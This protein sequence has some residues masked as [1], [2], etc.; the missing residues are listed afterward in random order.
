MAVGSTQKTIAHNIKSGLNTPVRSV[1]IIIEQSPIRIGRIGPVGIEF[2]LIVSNQT[3]ILKLL[4]A[5]PQ[6]PIERE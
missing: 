6:F 4:E 1:I 3:L 5:I 2:V